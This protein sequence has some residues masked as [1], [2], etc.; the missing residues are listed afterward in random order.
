MRTL[1]HRIKYYV[2][3][4]VATLVAIVL[5]FLAGCSPLRKYKAV[6][7]DY[8]RSQEKREILAPVCKLEFPAEA[9]KDSSS[10][11]KTVIVKDTSANALLRSQIAE[12]SR[13]LSERPDCP[14]I[15]SDSLYEAIK[16]KIKPEVHETTKTVRVIET[17]ID[18]AGMVVL[19]TQYRQLK[20]DYDQKEIALQ[21]ANKEID[22]LNIA[23]DKEGK[24]KIYFFILLAVS[25]GYVVLRIMKK[26]P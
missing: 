3:I 17:K 7:A 15:N 4:I 19:Q 26:V 11:E 10:S 21:T 16:S 20:A 22:R 13:K 1:N 18:S 6:A 25:V 23:L 12:L 5:V 8:P 14:Q 9:R 2:W 24:W